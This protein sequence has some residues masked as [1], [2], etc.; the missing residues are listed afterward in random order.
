MVVN[1]IYITLYN[2]IIFMCKQ[3]EREKEREEGHATRGNRVRFKLGGSVGY[4]T[5]RERREIW[6]LAETRKF[7]KN[8]SGSI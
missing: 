4:L 1:I 6:A 3:R 7:S 8:Q 5:K 2:K